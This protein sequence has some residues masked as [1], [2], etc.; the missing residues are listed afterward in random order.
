MGTLDPVIY[1]ENASGHVLLAPQ[2]IGKGIEVPRMVY[3]QRYKHQGYEWKEADTLDRVAKLEKRLIEQAVAE[4]AR[5]GQR[6]DEVRERA[7]SETRSNLRQRMASSDCEP[8]ER[9]F[10]SIYLDLN[11]E[12]RK[13]YLQ[14]FTERNNYLWGLQM[15]S[16]SKIEDRMG[17]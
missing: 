15:D 12:K 13:Q 17:E 5:Q 2:E 8:W 16:K 4:R 10:I 3:E 6:M 1:F 9:D 14:R 7:R 11:E